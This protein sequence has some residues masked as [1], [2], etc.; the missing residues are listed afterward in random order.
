MEEQAWAQTNIKN[1]VFKDSWKYA[2]GCARLFY[3]VYPNHAYT[4]AHLLLELMALLGCN[5]ILS[6]PC[7]CERS[8]VV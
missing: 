2:R 3:I 1:R 6:V 5:S 8:C 7:M 4:N